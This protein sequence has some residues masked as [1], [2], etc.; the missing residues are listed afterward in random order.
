MTRALTEAPKRSVRVVLLLTGAIDNNLVRQASCAK[1]GELFGAGI[2]IHEYEAG[3]LHGKTMI[4]DGFWT[5]IGS[6][7]LDNRSFALNELWRSKRLFTRADLGKVVAAKSLLTRDRGGMVGRDAAQRNSRGCG[8][9]SPAPREARARQAAGN[10]QNERSRG[11]R[12]DRR[13]VW[14]A[15]KA[16]RRDATEE[17]EPEQT[18]CRSHPE[19]AA[20]AENTCTARAP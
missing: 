3:L 6:T 9:T 19:T 16:G 5:T 8:G 20:P 1:I 13:R 12:Q 10:Q 17:T 11:A 15:G 7:N 4:V 2:E 18:D 14:N